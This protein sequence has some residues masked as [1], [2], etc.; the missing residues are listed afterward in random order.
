MRPILI[1]HI[2]Y[3]IGSIHVKEIALLGSPTAVCSYFSDLQQPR[4]PS[5]A[6]AS[7]NFIFIYRNLRPYYKFTL[8]SVQ[9]SSMETEIWSQL[10]DES[11]DAYSACQGL[12][13]LREEQ[14]VLSTRS[15]DLLALKN[16]EQQQDYVAK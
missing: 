5:I 4:I 9:L 16:P 14:I 6:I 15:L 3:S 12:S 8:P 2:T 11:M 10:V 13:K 1:V 7:G